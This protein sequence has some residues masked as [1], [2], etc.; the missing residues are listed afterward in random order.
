MA[1]IQVQKA[2]KL[3]RQKGEHANDVIKTH[4]EEQRKMETDE[5]RRKVEG[6]VGM[7]CLIWT[8]AVYVSSARAGSKS[9]AET[10]LEEHLIENSRSHGS[11]KRPVQAF[12]CFVFLFYG[13]CC[14]YT[15]RLADHS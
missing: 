7:F 1:F 15:R 2:T 14:A 10:V 9:T 11:L 12:R 8:S 3:E 6:E 13:I 5:G 4:G